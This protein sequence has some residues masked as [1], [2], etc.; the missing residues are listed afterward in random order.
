MDGV[1]ACSEELHLTNSGGTLTKIIGLISVALPT[2][3]V[4]E[5]DITTQDDA[6]VNRTRAGLLDLGSLDFEILH[7]PN[8]ATDLLLLEHV[9]SR[10]TRPGMIVTHDE[11]GTAINTNVNV[12][13]QEYNQG[14]G[15][16]PAGRRTSSGSIRLTELPS[17]SP[18]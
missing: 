11:N 3:S 5:V 9:T 1:L 13:V 15:T 10:E 2:Y 14:D 7:N 6:C 12:F 4:G 18:A 8:S 16:E 17:Q